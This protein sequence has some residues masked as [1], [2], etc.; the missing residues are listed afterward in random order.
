MSDHKKPM[1]PEL[2]AALEQHRLATDSPSQLSDS[3]RHGWHAGLAASQ[4]EVARLR[5][6]LKAE[7]LR[8]YEQRDA[9]VKGALL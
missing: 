8:G 5:G 6:A 1:P 4:E 7:Y 3:F 9:E 2:R